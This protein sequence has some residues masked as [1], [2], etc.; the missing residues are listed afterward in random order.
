L[1]AIFA[2]CSA[3]GKDSQPVEANTTSIRISVLANS[4]P[5]V[6][7]TPNDQKPNLLQPYSLQPHIKRPDRQISFFQYLTNAHQSFVKRL[8]TLWLHL[9]LWDMVDYFG[10]RSA[11]I[12][13]LPSRYS[14]YLSAPTASRALKRNSSQVWRWGL[15]GR[16]VSR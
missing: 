5:P 10:C 12:L 16:Q 14:A 2:A 1:E 15:P 4:T 9:G 11:G 6:S 7:W 13:P 8:L 3:L